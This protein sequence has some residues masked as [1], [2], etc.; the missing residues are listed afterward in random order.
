MNEEDRNNVVRVTTAHTSDYPDPISLTR[1]DT[2]TI[3]RE[4]DE[5]PGW[6]ATTTADGNTGWAP[7]ELLDIDESGGRA[8][9]RRDYTARELD[10]RI[11]QRL[12]VHSQLAGWLW[13]CTEDDEW[14]WVPE[15][16][17]ERV[18]NPDTR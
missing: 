7:K 18:E 8:T 1:G 11:G 4:D 6:V 2:V 17:V 5:Y 3:G 16:S 10:T 9:A 14:G 12:T 15:S 13:V